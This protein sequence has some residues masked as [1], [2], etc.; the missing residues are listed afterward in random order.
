LALGTYSQQER[1]NEYVRKESKQ[2]I[3]EDRTNKRKKR[4]N[5]KE[6]FSMKRMRK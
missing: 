6:K 5:K 1:K 2:E 3:N 4:C